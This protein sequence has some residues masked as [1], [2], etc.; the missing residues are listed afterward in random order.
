MQN[1][2]VS[3]KILDHLRTAVDSPLIKNRRFLD[4]EQM[5]RSE[6]LEV[7]E[8]IFNANVRD[9]EIKELPER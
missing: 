9:A 4:D 8:E 6:Q 7:L 2:N 3:A 1:T 5:I